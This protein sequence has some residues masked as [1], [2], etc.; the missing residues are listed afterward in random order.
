MA[1]LQLPKLLTWVRFPSPAPFVLCVAAAAAAPAQADAIDDYVRAEM[2]RQHIPGVALAI[3]NGDGTVRVAGYGEANVEHHVPVKPETIFQSGSVGKQFT[4]A[5]VQLL[6]AEGKLTLDDPLSRWFAPVPA[7]WERI[8]V[9]HLLT[10]TSG[11]PEYTEGEGA[12]SVDFRRDYSEDEL[13]EIAKRAALDFEPGSRWSYSNTGYLLL[14][15]L[16][17]RASGEFYGDYLA[18][19]VFGPLGMTTARVI[20]EEDIV[21]NRAAGYRS[22]DGALKNQEWVAPSINTT[23]DGALYL[24]A[25]DMVRWD[26]GL[27]DASVLSREQLAAAWTPMTLSNG[28]RTS[29]GFGWSIGEQRGSRLVEHGGSW[30]GFKSQISRYVDRG[31]TVIVLANHADADPGRIALAVAG[32][33]DPALALPDPAQAR[34]DPRPR[35]TNA[36]LDALVAWS[37]GRGSQAMT[38]A[39]AADSDR[40][41]RATYY[42]KLAAERLAGRRSFHYLD[43]VGVADRGIERRGSPIA[44]IL[45]LG[46]SGSAGDNLVTAYLDRDGRVAALTIDGS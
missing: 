5:A 42:R 43:E 20:S 30:Q 9:R 2:E 39:F 37:D 22:V 19:R 41:P 1:E 13:V 28:E 3:V 7:A 25:L 29:Y 45:Y 35:R 8:T 27:R 15:A 46:I 16:I 32:L 21:P 17:R 6:A 26:R 10:H 14:G 33:A 34:A 4:A 40:S 12:A 18:R 24:T 36:V 38:G 44:T 23:A 31:L 11:I